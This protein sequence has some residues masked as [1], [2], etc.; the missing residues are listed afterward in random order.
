MFS[1]RTCLKSVSALGTS[2]STSFAPRLR[3]PGCERRSQP[4]DQRGDIRVQPSHRFVEEQHSSE[5]GHADQDGR[6]NEREPDDERPAPPALS[7]PPLACHL[8]IISAVPRPE[9]SAVPAS[10]DQGV[11]TAGLGT[12]LK[13]ACDRWPR[14]GSERGVG[15]GRSA[16]RHGHP[17]RRR[18]LAGQGDAMSCAR[19]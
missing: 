17:A 11:E 1:A 19:V 13:R 3:D 14:G 9:G 4:D 12:Q 16:A 6:K 2:R 10:Q 7:V 8:S 18:C 15:L 5:R